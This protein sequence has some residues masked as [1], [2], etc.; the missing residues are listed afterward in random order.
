M[1]DNQSL[2]LEIAQRIATGGSLGAML[3]DILNATLRL[4]G[5]DGIRLVLDANPTPMAY[6][7]GPAAGKM[8]KFDSLIPSALANQESLIVSNVVEAKNKLATSLAPLK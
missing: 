7:S 2:L 4:A 3:P 5:A 8:V 6:A 1:N